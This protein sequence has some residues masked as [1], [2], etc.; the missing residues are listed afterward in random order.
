MNGWYSAARS[1]HGTNGGM[2]QFCPAGLNSSG[3]APMRSGSASRS[4]YSWLSAPTGEKPTARSPM[5]VTPV[6]VTCGEL[7]LDLRSAATRGSCARCSRSGSASASS[8]GSGHVAPVAA[9]H[10]AAGVPPRDRS[11]LGRRGACAFERLEVGVE[12]RLEHRS[13]RDPHVVSVDELVAPAPQ[14]R[15][16]RRVDAEQQRAPRPARAGVVGARLLRQ[17]RCRLV[18]RAEQQR[19]AAGGDDVLGRA[20]HVVQ[21]AD[22]PRRRAPQRV[23]LR[24]HTPHAR[25]LRALRRVHDQRVDG[26]PSRGHQFVVAD[27]QVVGQAITDAEPRAVLELHVAAFHSR[28]LSPARTN[29][30]GRPGCGVPIARAQAFAGGER[31]VVPSAVDVVV[32][33]GDA[34]LVV[35]P[36]IVARSYT[37]RRGQTV[38]RAAT[39]PDERTV[40]ARCATSCG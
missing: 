27:R 9:Q 6:A 15:W 18:Q 13:F 34:P 29:H 32:A 37:P 7:C 38:D 14:V 31:R 39:S 12:L 40:C 25:H 16:R 24:G 35:H 23:H 3:G 1:R 17:G 19:T 20:A 11:W 2:P 8:S 36:P 22:A 5:S 4:R 10:V 30:I 28:W 21:V 26:L 33:V